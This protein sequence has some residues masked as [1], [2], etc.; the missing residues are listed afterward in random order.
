MPACPGITLAL[1][2]MMTSCPGITL[3]VEGMMTSCPV[4]TI[5][6]EGMMTSCPGI[7]I[8]VEGMMTSCPVITRQHYAIALN[9]LHVFIVRVY[10]VIPFYFVTFNVQAIVDFIVCAK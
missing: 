2:G 1:E 10:F 7:T 3:A 4:I 9:S 6:V 8:A 5:A